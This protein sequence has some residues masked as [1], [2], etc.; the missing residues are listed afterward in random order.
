MTVSWTQKT[1]NCSL[2]YTWN[3]PGIDFWAWQHVADA[4]IMIQV[5][6]ETEDNSLLKSLYHDCAV[7]LTDSGLFVNTTKIIWEENTTFLAFMEVNALTSFSH[8]T[9]VNLKTLNI[10]TLTQF[11]LL[12]LHV[13]H[14]QC[15]SLPPQLCTMTIVSPDITVGPHRSIA[16][17]CDQCIG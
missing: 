17:A 1:G 16:S 13:V 2:Q 5:R 11:Q 3:N 6:R 7:L 14:L 15:W 10:E 9:R 12:M 8:L 4:Q